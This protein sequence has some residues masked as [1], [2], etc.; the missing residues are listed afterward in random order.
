MR[1]FTA[2]V[3]APRSWPKSSL[4]SNC[5]GMAAQLTATNG[6]LWRSLC[7]QI[8]LA[9][10]SLPVPLSP[11]IRTVVS[12]LANCP[13]SL[14]TSRIGSLCPTISDSKSSG[15]SSGRPPGSKL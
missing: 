15:C 7:C 14:N 1:W 4:S 3:K 13:M 6:P 11:V 12:V 5:S 10:S 9:T 8:A 2:P